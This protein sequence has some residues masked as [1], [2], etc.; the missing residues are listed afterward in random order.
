MGQSRWVIAM[1]FLL[2]TLSWSYAS[3]ENVEKAAAPLPLHTL[4]FPTTPKEAREEIQI[5]MDKSLSMAIKQLEQDGTFYPFLAGLNDVGVVELVGVPVTLERPSPDLMVEA[6]RRA[7]KQLARKKRFRALALYIDFVAERKDTLIRQPGI[8]IEL[9][10]AFPDNLSVFIP[11]MRN[12]KRQIRLMT[13]QFMPGKQRMY[14][15][16]K[17]EPIQGQPSQ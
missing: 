16:S 17:Q 13:P 6:L 12:Q 14:V 4:P 11:Y 5:L 7:G 10:H 1:L 15:V 8:R 3:E 9:E 2:S